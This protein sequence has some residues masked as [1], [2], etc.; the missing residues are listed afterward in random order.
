M[1][2]A[3][4]LLVVTAAPRV[5]VVVHPAGFSDDD[6][7]RIQEK[8]GQEVA[9]TGVEL[10]A[11]SRSLEVKTEC[12]T[13]RSCAREVLR[14]ADASYLVWVEALRAGGQVQLEAHLIDAEGRA[15][16]SSETAA[17]ADEITGAGTVLPAAVTTPLKAAAKAAATPPTTTVTPPVK[18]PP[19]PTKINPLAPVTTA[20]TPAEPAGIS[21]LAVGGIAAV[22]TGAIL[23]LGGGALS[24]SQFQ[25]IRDPHSL[26]AEKQSAANVMTSMLLVSGIGVAV[27]GAGG[28]LLYLGL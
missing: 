19:P 16:A 4:A 5:A 26:G 27:A 3:L 13:D 22:G 14:A 7:R 12:L 24:V 28:V 11:L 23:A 18:T 25:I 9:A 15:A 6:A 10:W 8:V 2:L 17:R 21:T 1:N 20:P